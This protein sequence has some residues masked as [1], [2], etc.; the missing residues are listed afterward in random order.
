[1]LHP[2]NHSI[3]RCLLA[4]ALASG[5][6]ACSHGHDDNAAA[7]PPA[8]TVQNNLYKVPDGSPL[9]KELLVQPVQMRQAPHAM[10]FPAN[11]EADPA[12]TAN[13]LP[14]L[15]GKLIELNLR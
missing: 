15:T 11:V 3:M 8:F 1:M 14:A 5:M 7:P 4:L 6:A 9:R 13:V 12:R 2:F 10:V